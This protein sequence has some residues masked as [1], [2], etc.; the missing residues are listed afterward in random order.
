MQPLERCRIPQLGE[1]GSIVI[2]FGS[3]AQ[4]H[5]AIT[6]LAEIIASSESSIDFEFREIDRVSQKTLLNILQDQ[7]TSVHAA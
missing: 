5:R 4:G 2:N 1:Q 6:A 7:Q 3:K